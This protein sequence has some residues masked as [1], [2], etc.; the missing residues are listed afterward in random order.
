MEE[1]L[2]VAFCR[3]NHSGEVGLAVFKEKLYDNG[4]KRR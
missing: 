2:T 4:G 1:V 3:D